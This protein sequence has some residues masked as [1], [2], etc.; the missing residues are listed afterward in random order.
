MS[1]SLDRV[2]RAGIGAGILA[3]VVAAVVVPTS[4]L[5]GSARAI[6]SS[7]KAVSRRVPRRT[8]TIDTTAAAGVE[9]PYARAALSI[10][11]GDGL[12]VRG[13]AFD[14]ATRR[15]AERLVYRVD[16]GPWR[17]AAYH[18]PRPDV[19]AAFALPGA[20][21]SGFRADVASSALAPG[22]H[23]VTFAM[24]TRTIELPIRESVTVVVRAR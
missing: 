24:I 15:S 9:R 7:G 14:P 8:F 21:D 20:L 1:D 19:A 12:A 11:R 13:W 18:V 16:R 3:C 22:T 23:R 6:W 2:V 17:D 10:K 4:P 5:T